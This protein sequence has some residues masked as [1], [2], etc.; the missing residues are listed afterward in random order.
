[1]AKGEDSA[2]RQSLH[3]ELE[4]EVG[5]HLDTAI[6]AWVAAVGTHNAPLRS[7]EEFL[8]VPPKGASHSEVYG[9]VES[10]LPFPQKISFPVAVLW[11][12]EEMP[13]HFNK[14]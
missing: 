10:L 6:R 2:G 11:G 13:Q 7:L 12:Q 9:I 4:P 1:M 3:K 8:M 14:V 5:G